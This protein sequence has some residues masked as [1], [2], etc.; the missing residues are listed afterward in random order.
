MDKSILKILVLLIS[1]C[2]ASLVMAEKDDCDFTTSYDASISKKFFKR[3]ELGVTES[4]SLKNNS[5]TV[6]KVSTKVDLSYAI[7]RKIFKVGVSYTA[8]AKE[9]KTEYFFNQKFSGYTNLKYDVNRFSF[10]WKSRYEMTDRPERKVEKQWV[11]Y[12]RNK[13][14]VEAKLPKVPLYPSLA[15]EMFYRTNNYKGNAITKMRYEFAMK[16]EF[17]KKNS[18]KLY[19]QYDDAMNVVH[20]LDKSNLGL[21]YQFSL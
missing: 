13:L 18:L 5:T 20:P 8:I 4:L 17:N 10:A 15:A 16:Y 7:V 19:Y 9:R 2:C 21:A 6:G 1:L 11:G 3:L 14:S 12:W